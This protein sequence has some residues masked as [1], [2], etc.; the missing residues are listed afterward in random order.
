MKNS[1]KIM[2]ACCLMMAQTAF[3]Q[4]INLTFKGE[5]TDGKYVQMDSV[6]IENISR[7]WTETL[8]YPDTVLTLVDETGVSEV[9]NNYLKCFS[10][11]NP[12]NGRTNVMLSME[13]EEAVTL[14]VYNLT[15]Q[16]MM[17]KRVRVAA[18]ENHFEIS[19]DRPQVYFLVVR[20][21]QG[22]LVQ[23]LINTGSSA[24]NSITYIGSQ[25]IGAVK[26]QKLLSTKIFHSG[27]VLKI[28]GY[29]TYFGVEIASN[30]ILQPQ[31]AN[32][33]FTLF[34]TLQ[35]VTLPTL[36][37]IAVSN[38]TDSSA[39]TGGIITNDGG[40]TVTARG[41]CWD[42]TSNPTISNN[43]TTDGLDT[44]SFTS[45][46]T[47]LLAGTTYYI[48][49]YATNAIG[50]AYGNE[51]YFTTT[52]GAN[53]YAVFSVSST[54]Y[55]VFSPGNL[56]WSATNG[57]N[58]ATTHVVAGNGTAAGTWRFAS[59]QWDMIGSANGNISSTDT[60]WIDLF[61]WGTSGYSNK[62]PYMTSITSTDYGNGN[63]SIAGTNYDW[64][65]YNAIYN[66]KTQTTDAPGTWRTLTKDEWVYLLN[67]R[68]TAS[69]I[70][71]AK[72]T[73]CGIVGLII[74]P[75]NWSN[76][77]Y[78][79]TNVNTVS[80]AY[81]S[82]IIGAIDWAKMENV[83]CVFLP[84]AGYRSGSS[85][86]NVGSSGGYWSATYYDRGGAYNLNFNS[87]YLYPSAND[88]RYYG[89]SVRLVRDVE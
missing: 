12:C 66:P 19:I 72:A 4:N 11:P 5:D 23:K 38:I 9:E 26:T 68:P 42:T 81:T 44:G 88:N 30:E 58:I 83:G 75:D 18:G 16:Q 64:G 52:N 65:A 33:N 25:E 70:R 40:T 2:A 36:I 63:N 6:R 22:Q 55:V 86:S 43:H 61:G 49:A 3:S 20:T 50:T 31:T 53:S 14:Q 74:V 57:G 79:L 62:Y 15:G 87:S 84:A 77:Y 1:I 45:N 51:I 47:G 21:A 82:N 28:T 39:V 17:E 78:P 56:Q 7:S 73:V 69:S 13:Q 24:G 41:I 10:Y 29:V 67:T 54:D 85:V 46:M 37:T 34:F 32:E 71:Y 60:G 48:R 27:D 59:N 80:A 89:R 76:T 35:N 8:I